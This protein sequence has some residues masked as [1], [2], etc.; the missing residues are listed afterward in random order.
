MQKTTQLIALENVM[1]EDQPTNYKRTPRNVL[2]HT[3]TTSPDTLNF[4]CDVLTDVV[5]I[6]EL[7]QLVENDKNK[8]LT[9][10]R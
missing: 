5:L 1:K 10:A 6:I 3:T 4:Y 2:N 9:I 8:R 7:K